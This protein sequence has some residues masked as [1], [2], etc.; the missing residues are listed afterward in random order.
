MGSSTNQPPSLSNEQVVYSIRSV[1]VDITPH[2]FPIPLA[3]MN[4]VSVPRTIGSLSIVT[5]KT[6]AGGQ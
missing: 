6:M 4:A 5:M 2:S 3:L 1:A